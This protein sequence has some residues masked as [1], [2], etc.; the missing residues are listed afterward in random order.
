[1]I[2]RSTI[3]LFALALAAAAPVVARAEE[4]VT[5]KFGFPA[6]VTSYVNTKGMA[7]WIEDVEKASGGTLKIKLFAGPTLGTFRD[8]YDRTLSGVS[9]ISFGIF[10]PLAGQFQRVQVS[11][12]PFE[13]RQARESSVALWRLYAKKM[14]DPE[15]DKVKVLAL[16]DFPSSYIH[17]NVPIKSADDMKGLKFSVSSRTIGQ[18]V[19]ALGGSPVS[20]T[21]PEI[22]QSMSRGVIN[23]V[24]TA[25]TAVKTFK[26][27]EVTKYHLEAPLGEAPAYVFINKAVYE[28]LPEKAKQAIDK[29]SGEAFSKHLG[30]ENDTA[31]RETSKEVEAM[32]GHTVGELSKD[33][34]EHWRALMQPVIDEW[35]KETPDGAKILAAFRE[36]LKTICAGH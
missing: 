29:Y 16:F 31:D 25:W 17:T 35:V 9:D 14:F 24:V 19:V 18:I 20:T 30:S 34:Y 1:M 21:P 12:L 11:S 22:Y 10:G 13:L 8:I 36:E 26:L 5:L 3:G 23:G 6:P 2:F 28:R 33:Q 4:P 32:S 15:F 7:P 27:H